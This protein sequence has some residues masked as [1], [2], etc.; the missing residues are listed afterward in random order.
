MFISVD[1]LGMIVVFNFLK[2]NPCLFSTRGPIHCRGNR[3]N[4]LSMTMLLGLVLV[5]FILQ[6][7]GSKKVILFFLLYSIRS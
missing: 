4:L 5:D 2:F 1:S 7:R 3:G 6:E